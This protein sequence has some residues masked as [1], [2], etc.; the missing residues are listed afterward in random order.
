MYYEPVM[1][2]IKLREN[3]T[4]KLCNVIINVLLGRSVDITEYY[5]PWHLRNMI[6]KNDEISGYFKKMK[7][8]L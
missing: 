8:L 4:T 6:R 7:I 2:N 1:H 3:E 5:I